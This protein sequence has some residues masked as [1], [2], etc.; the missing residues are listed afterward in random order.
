MTKKYGGCTWS[1]WWAFQTLLLT[2]GLG[3]GYVLKNF[4]MPVVNGH[5]WWQAPSAAV[6]LVIAAASLVYF[7]SMLIMGAEKLLEDHVN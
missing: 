2:A 4:I 6:L 3:S 5:L 1:G 7:V